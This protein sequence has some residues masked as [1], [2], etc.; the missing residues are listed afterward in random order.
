[1]RDLPWRRTRDPWAV[2]VSEVMLQQTQVARVVPKWH[3]FLEPCSRPRRCAAAPLGDVLRLWQGLGYPRRAVN[4]HAAA[5]AIAEAGELPATLDGLLALPGVG[6]YTARAVLVFAFEADAAVVDT[7]IARVLARMAG[8]RLTAS[9]AQ[10]AA[11]ALR[12]RRRGVGVEPVPDGPRRDA[13]PAGAAACDE[14]PLAATV[15]VARRAAP[16][17]AIGSAG[18]ERSP[19]AVRGQR[20]AGTRPADEGLGRRTAER[21]SAGRGRWAATC[22]GPTVADRLIDDGLRR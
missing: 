10:A 6:P 19:G 18:R 14:C 16:D 17:P 1:M 5:Q 20:S 21:R 9:E 7:N 2:L 8:R 15:R 12:C 11:D 13:V 3:A 22:R 4:L